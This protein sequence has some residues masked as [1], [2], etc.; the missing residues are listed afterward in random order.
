MKENRKTNSLLKI[1]I[2]LLIVLIAIML[3]ERNK[4]TDL[5]SS[6]TQESKIENLRTEVIKKDEV[7]I[8]KQTEETEVNEVVINA[9]ETPLVDFVYG[10]EMVDGLK[11]RYNSEEPYD[12]TFLADLGDIKN[13]E[14]LKF[15]FDSDNKGTTIGI[16]N[17]KNGQ[18][19]KV[20]VEQVKFDD[21]L[22]LDSN[23]LTRLFS[24]QEELLDVIV[25]NFEIVEYVSE[26]ILLEEG[27]VVTE[28]P[29]FKIP[30][31]N[32]WE[33]YLNVEQINGKPYKVVFRCNF[34][35]YEPVELFTY[36]FGEG[37]EGV[38]GYLSGVPVGLSIGAAE[39]DKNWSQEQN[40]IFY[41]MREEMNYIIDHLVATG[42]FS[43][44]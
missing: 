12:V 42:E 17:D 22:G 32:E 20:S 16:I 8:K 24:V 41:N 21:S 9:I 27:Y 10:F 11:V 39:A 18:Q 13:I 25:S 1:C 15:Y 34:E 2:V 4:K 33:E 7:N 31:S 6:T 44:N 35:G 23:E 14:I 29:Y 5:E 38:L 19:V 26:D 43:F 36:M 30:F 37:A 28:T 3:F 40:D